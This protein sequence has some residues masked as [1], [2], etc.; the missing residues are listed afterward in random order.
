MLKFHNRCK[1]YVS[2]DNAKVSSTSVVLPPCWKFLTF[3]GPE[4]F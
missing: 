1:D 3:Y 4:I 2:E